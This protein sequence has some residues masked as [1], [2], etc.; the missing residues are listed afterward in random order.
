MTKECP[1]TNDQTARTPPLRLFW[2]TFGHWGLVI[3]WSLVIGHW[4]LAVRGPHWSL[5][6]RQC[7]PALS[8]G[9]HLYPYLF[10]WTPWVSRLPS[11]RSNG[12]SE[13]SP[14]D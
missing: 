3:H 12:P 10:R 8:P 2:S 9:A 1:M 11:S 6:Q 13:P 14:Q 7:T 4:S 5:I